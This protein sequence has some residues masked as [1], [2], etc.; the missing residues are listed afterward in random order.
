MRSGGLYYTHREGLMVKTILASAALLLL[1]ISLCGCSSQGQAG[2][3]EPQITTSLMQLNEDGTMT[4]VE[5]LE[6]VE[7][8][9]S[10]DELIAKEGEIEELLEGQSYIEEAFANLFY[11][12]G[13]PEKVCFMVTLKGD[14]LEEHMDEISALVTGGLDSCDLENSCIRDLRGAVYPA[15]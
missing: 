2:A 7:G 11:R 14:G 12:E 4:E 13:E 5:K 10:T 3:S 9:L 6:P 15:K 8:Q 1:P